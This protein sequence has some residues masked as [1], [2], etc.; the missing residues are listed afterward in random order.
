MNGEFWR[1]EDGQTKLLADTGRE[2]DAI[3][4]LD[5]ARIL[6]AGSTGYLAI[7]DLISETLER[8]SLES[9]GIPKPGRSIYAACP[10]PNGF[11]LCGSN[12]LLLR[13]TSAGVEQ[14]FPCGPSNGM[15]SFHSVAEAGGTIFVS[16]TEATSPFVASV[17]GEQLLRLDLAT[18]GHEGR[19]SSLT[20]GNSLS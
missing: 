8:I 18:P 20:G 12:Q 3:V 19:F 6:L 17:S 14:L 15:R 2:L 10:S 16:V 7:Y 13:W 5:S 11:L 9:Y 1:I 4:P